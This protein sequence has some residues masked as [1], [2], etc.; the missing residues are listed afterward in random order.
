MSRAEDGPADMPRTMR[1]AVY[2]GRDDIRVEELPVPCIGRGE[3]LVRIRVCGVCHT[4]LKK[5]HH[6]LQ[7][8]PR[9]YGHEMAGTIAA[10]G[11][12]VKGWRLGDRVAVFHHIPCGA[13][14][15]CERRE[16]AQCLGYKRTGTTAGFEPSGGGFA[17]FIRVMPWIVQGG[18]VRVPRGI[19]LEEASFLEPV[20]TCLKGVYRLGL[21]RGDSVLVFG[22]GPIGLLITQ[23]VKARGGRVLALDL[24]P[25]RLRM[26]RKLGAAAAFDPCGQAWKKAVLKLTASRGADA[27]ILAV[28]SDV[29]FAQA[30]TAVRPGGRVLLFAHTQR[31]DALALDAAAV[32]VDEKTVLGSYSASL[33]LNPETAR[34]VFSRRVKVAPLITHRF[35]LDDIAAAFTLAAQPT[36]DSLKVLVQP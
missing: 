25:E 31:G 35:G 10:L 33:D 14:Y 4:D 29:A 9:V 26:A 3:V 27:A 23:L 24:L 7:K 21:R 12:G 19:T 22:Q 16:Y 8:P 28:P 32:C 5:I 15:Y 18:M 13:C 2:R 36:K 11:P 1:A 17:Q 34:L 30:L 20:N 6:A